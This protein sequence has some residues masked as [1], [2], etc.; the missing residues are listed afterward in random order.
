M[1]RELYRK[2]DNVILESSSRSAVKQWRSVPPESTY[3][4]SA[5]SSAV[6]VPN[7]ATAPHEYAC[8]FH[9]LSTH[10]ASNSAAEWTQ[11]GREERA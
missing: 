4:V 2:R 7:A 11:Q 8:C 5:S 10:V 3:L 6:A 9:H 1:E